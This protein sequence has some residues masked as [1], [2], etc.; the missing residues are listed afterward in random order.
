MNNIKKL[1]GAFVLSCMLV[2]CGG[3]GGDPGPTPPPADTTPPVILLNGA[4]S[5]TIEAG[6]VY[7]E[8]GATATDNVDGN[9]SLSIAVTGTVN[10]SALGVYTIN[11]NVSDSSGNPA[12]QVTRT[13]TVV[14]TTPP[15]VTASGVNPES[16]LLGGVYVDAGAT[17]LDNLDGVVS[18]VP[19]GSVN[20]AVLG[21]Y[22]LTYTATDAHSNVG[23]A[24]RV[25]NVI[26]VPDAT[27]P[28]I[29]IN[30]ANPQTI[31]VGSSYV[32]LGATATDNVDG[33]ISASIVITG[34]VNTSIVGVYA[35]Y[36]NVSDSSNLPATQ[37]TRIIN[38]VAVPMLTTQ[39][40]LY[41]GYDAALKLQYGGDGAIYSSDL[42]TGV[43]TRLYGGYQCPPGGCSVLVPEQI[44]PTRTGGKVV[45]QGNN[46]P[47]LAVL[48]LSLPLS[49]TNPMCGSEPWNS[50]SESNFDV[51]QSGD[52]GVISQRMDAVN[53]PQQ[54]SIVLHRLNLENGAGGTM[55]VTDGTLID[56]SPVFTTAGNQNS[57]L[58]I[59]FVRGG[60]EVWQQS[61]DP[62]NGVLVGSATLFISNVVDGVRALSV[63]ADYTKVAFMRNVGGI[64]HIFTKSLAGGAEVDLGA[65]T[66]PYWATD[67]SDLIKFTDNNLL[68]AILSDG[69]GKKQ[70]QVPDNIAIGNFI[71]VGM[72]GDRCLGNTVFRPAGF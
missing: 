58:T 14:D 3:G 23:T 47:C 48:S 72:C 18:V 57:V 39:K 52:V 66:D 44:V 10:T 12:T 51:T 9:I 71:G 49:V 30:G 70:I 56:T 68:W 61:V 13:V 11:Y 21:A 55:V 67:G 60:N 16:V 19:S 50:Y 15:V 31:Y 24:S 62:A 1:L 43:N 25:V 42:A 63:N 36:Y 33:D 41:P 54:K 38:V 59:L 17:A 8:L 7:A 46:I 37:V 64:T 28:V 22:T 20:T 53:F 32:E 34:T 35:K 2:A 65:G 69:T 5:V 27:P 26:P 45:F 40:L 6:S 29:S 4:L